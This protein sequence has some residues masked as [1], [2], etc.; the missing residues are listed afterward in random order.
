MSE[1]VTKRENETEEE[2]SPAEEIMNRK[3]AAQMKFQ[4]TVGILMVITGLW[5]VLAIIEARGGIQNMNLGPEYKE[6]WRMWLADE[7]NKWWVQMLPIIFGDGTVHDMPP[8]DGNV[9]N[10][11]GSEEL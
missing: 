3:H 1:P 7:N 9:D 11:L 8:F 6:G 2:E 5:G 10:A 4:N